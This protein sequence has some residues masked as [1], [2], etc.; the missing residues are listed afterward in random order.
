VRRDLVA[1]ARML[2]PATL[3]L[4]LVTAFVPGRLALA[5]RIYALILCGTAL[6]AAL[7]ALRRAYP[8]AM[9]RGRKA[10]GTA[11]G[12]PAPSSLARLED[13]TALGVA[14]AFHLHLRL[15]PRLR[16][17]ASGVLEARRHV[18]LDGDPEKAQEILGAETWDLLRPDRPPPEDRLASGLPVDE[19]RRV[20]DSLERL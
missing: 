7:R 3:A 5:V 10:R 12:R 11:R 8:P 15:R 2:I 13:E 1:A 17:I 6:L 14:G 20:V 9:P 16:T 19:L 18:S 4:G